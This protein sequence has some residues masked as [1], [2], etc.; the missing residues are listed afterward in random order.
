M[1]EETKKMQNESDSGFVMLE[2]G[3]EENLS[4]KGMMVKPCGVITVQSLKLLMG[5]FEN[6]A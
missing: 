1:G 4:A 6:S 5:L 2:G 3:K